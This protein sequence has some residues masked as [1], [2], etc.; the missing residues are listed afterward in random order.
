MEKEE[1]GSEE[2]K[3]LFCWNDVT[4]SE[5]MNNRLRRV[6]QDK[7]NIGWAKNAEICKPDDGKT[8]CISKDGN[9]AVIKLE[10]E[11]EKEKAIL[12]TS[13]GKTYDLKVNSK[14]GKNGK[15]YIVYEKKEVAYLLVKVKPKYSEEFCITMVACKELCNKVSQ[16]KNLAQIDEVYSVL[17]PYDFFMTL[18]GENDDKI[19]KTIFKIRETL[20]SYINDTLTLTKFKIPLTKEE[21]AKKF[22][23][24]IGEEYLPHINGGKIPDEGLKP[25]DR[26]DLREISNAEPTSLEKLLEGAKK[27]LET[28]DLQ[29]R[30]DVLTNRVD[31]LEKKG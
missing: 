4:Q 12:T 28:E 14:N 15:R 8:I 24:I 19:N 11:K 9:S 7:F 3:Y 5:S 13:D 21:L 26:I 6:L 2:K 1:N 17:G 27:F 10:G 23:E 16:S 31:D 29:K 22:K 18:S 20:G 25:Y 30:I